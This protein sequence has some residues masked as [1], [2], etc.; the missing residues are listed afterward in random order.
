M[1]VG[2]VISAVFVGAG[3][4]AFFY[5]L[6]GVLFLMACI[7]YDLP[8]EIGL[9]VYLNQMVLSAVLIGVGLNRLRGGNVTRLFSRF[10]IIAI[11]AF[12]L[13]VFISAVNAEQFNTVIKQWLRWM[14]IILTAWL[15]FSVVVTRREMKMI[16]AV[17]IGAAVIA[18]IIGIV[19]TIAGPE[20][21]FNTGKYIF[22]VDR[23]ATMRA[24]STF[25]H[26]NQFAGYLILAIPI[27]FIQFVEMK[28]IGQRMAVGFLAVIMLTALIFTFS[29]GGWLAMTL[30]GGILIYLNIPKKM[31]MIIALVITVVVTVVVLYQGPLEKTRQ[32][33][34]HRVASFTQPEKEDSFGFRGVCIKTAV[35]MIRQHPWVGFGAG[36]Y[37]HNIRK[38]FD[39]K[40]YAWEA[41]NKHI[42]S[43]YLQIWIEIGLLGLVA[44]LVLCFSMLFRMGRSFFNNPPD[45]ERQ[46]LSGVIGA[47]L[48]F[49]IHNFFDVLSM[50]ARGIHF[51]VLVG[52]G[53]AIVAYMESNQPRPEPLPS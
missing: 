34:M 32:A 48:A 26:P 28:K 12:S 2:I 21:G 38:Y 33:V 53:I 22:T 1:V 41:I 16:A 23:G 20:A 7:P 17:I 15:V 19:Q 8:F 49:L 9:T 10:W 45:Y 52:L 39:E 4:S 3:V 6:L 35:K 18:S 30:I 29:R 14:E 42:H 40:Y 51:G 36:G 47:V 37:E 5:P 50:Y 25:G 11:A 43:W 13:A 27:A 44:F 46:L 31:K 24:Y